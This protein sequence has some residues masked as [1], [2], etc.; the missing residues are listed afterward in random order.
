MAIPLRTVL[1]DT[2]EVTGTALPF[3]HV[4]FTLTRPDLYDDPE[5]D[6]GGII[7]A[8]SSVVDCDADGQ[9]AGELFPNVL[10]SQGT[11]YSVEVFDE[12]WARVFPLD[13]VCPA[14]MPDLDNVLLHTILFTV[15]P[16]SKSDAER[17]TLQAQEA[18]TRAEN[19]AALAPQGPQGEPGEPGPQGPPGE[20]G[21]QGPPGDDGAPGAAGAQGD[22]GPQGIPG[23]Q[24]EIGPQGPKGDTGD[25][26]PQGIKGDT[27]DVGPQGPK[28]DT[29]D[30]GPQGNIGPQG[31]KGDTGN[32]GPAGP[33]GGADKQVI[34]ND[35][36]STAAGSNNF[37]WDK[38]T[39]TLTVTGAIRGSVSV[40]VGPAT[41][42]GYMLKNSG[43]VMQV[44]SGVDS[45]FY[46]VESSAYRLYDVFVD[47]ANYKR[48]SLR[49]SG[50]G[51]LQLVHESAGTGNATSIGIF[52]LTQLNLGSGGVTTKWQID[53]TGHLLAWT[54][55]AF[56]IG[57]AA[58]TRTPRSIY[59]ATSMVAPT[60]QSADTT[61]ANLPVAAAGNRGQRRHVTDS[62]VAASGNFGASVVGGGANVV[63]VFSTG[64]A[65]IIA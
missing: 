15:A 33:V 24:G 18:A 22:I 17:F 27:G 2:Y 43:G 61:V 29:G 39:N 62:S 4:R 58:G 12:K 63:P 50:G 37:T 57:N 20:P 16:V 6:E 26:G 55:N 9:G 41:S 56:D 5:L 51:E 59:A 10:G 11:N 53:T 19:A 28:G 31:P 23:P 1:I 34:F 38:A 21:P 47:A 46:P 65:W 7:A 44:R 14:S 30:Q 13:G 42:S 45:A 35:G 32:T 40:A 48:G 64:A 36:G 54:P 8:G 25:A 3:A 52:P 60:F 49:M